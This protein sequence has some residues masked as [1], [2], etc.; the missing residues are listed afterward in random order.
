[1]PL[2]LLA[3]KFS[4]DSKIIALLTCSKAKHKTQQKKFKGKLKAAFNIL[5]FVFVFVFVLTFSYF[6]NRNIGR[7]FSLARIGG[8]FR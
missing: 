3:A 7:K 8:I 2:K 5:K 1:M 6:I 4:K